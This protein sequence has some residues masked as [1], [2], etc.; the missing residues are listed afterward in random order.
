MGVE[1]RSPDDAVAEL[2]VISLGGLEGPG[3]SERFLRSE[4]E[5]AYA[6]SMMAVLVVLL[7]ILAALMVLA[8]TRRD[9]DV[10]SG[11]WR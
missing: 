3:G 8:W 1:R 6:F 11:R 9:R 2:V 4:P 7:V 5:G 10:R